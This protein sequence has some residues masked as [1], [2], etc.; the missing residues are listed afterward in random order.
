MNM[1][2]YA[3][4]RDD[5]LNLAMRIIKE[6]GIE[7]LEKEIE[8]RKAF[9]VNTSYSMK[10]LNAMTGTIKARTVSTVCALSIATLMDEFG[11][12]KV[13]LD[14]F[15]HRFEGKAECVLGDFVTW[16]DIVDDVKERTG[17]DLELKFMMS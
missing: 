6:K 17:I 3:K 14:R 2:D 11:M 10:E 15:I 4:G 13:R 12:G 5:G 8:D 1:K 7:G 9:G 16:Q